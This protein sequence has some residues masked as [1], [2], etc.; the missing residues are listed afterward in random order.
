MTRYA[1]LGLTLLS[2]GLPNS[3]KSQP[4][5]LSDQSVVN[6]SAEGILVCSPDGT[7]LLWNNGELRRWGSKEVL[8]IS[9]EGVTR[10]PDG[11][12][13][14]C[15]PVDP[16]VTGTDQ[17]SGLDAFRAVHFERVFMWQYR[18]SVA[19]FVAVLAI[20]S[21]GLALAVAHFV[22]FSRGAA[23]EKTLG[24]DLEVSGTG[25]KVSSPV[26]GVIIL[27]LS[28]AFLYLYLVHVYPIQFIDPS[29]PSPG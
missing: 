5:I 19:I 12:A 26:I 7:A 14:P 6:E 11:D 28:M 3:G 10:V 1:V 9:G 24:T 13:S 17:S 16:A 29:M 25:F 27:T 8:T 22:V 2:F 18:S 20:V 23:G 4:M 15:P 21:T